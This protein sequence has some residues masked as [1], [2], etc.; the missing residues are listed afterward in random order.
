ML[1][2]DLAGLTKPSQ[3]A[4]LIKTVLKDYELFVMPGMPNLSG[5][6][7]V[8][9]SRTVLTPELALKRA[10]TL[11]RG[12]AEEIGMADVKELPNKQV[13]TLDAQTTF[14]TLSQQS[15]AQVQ[16]LQFENPP[17]ITNTLSNLEAVQQLEQIMQLGVIFNKLSNPR[18]YE[19][20]G[21]LGF[22]EDGK[23]M[24]ICGEFQEVATGKDSSII[25]QTLLADNLNN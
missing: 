12:I 17:D 23:I 5:E 10:E 19:V 13:V 7:E 22:V 3:V 25:C 14:Q 1:A 9:T 4:A 8:K 16:T 18:I 2:I 24:M 15:Y 6:I 11:W 20:T 21:D